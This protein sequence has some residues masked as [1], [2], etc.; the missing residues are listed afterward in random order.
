[1]ADSIDMA[2]AHDRLF[3]A[4]S[5]LKRAK[6]RLVVA[7]DAVDHAT[8]EYNEAHDEFRSSSRAVIAG[9]R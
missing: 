1:M 8:M 4:S 3:K 2:A 6:S 7:E 9:N 5:A